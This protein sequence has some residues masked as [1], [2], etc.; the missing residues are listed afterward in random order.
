[1]ELGVS[2]WDS[3]THYNV[4]AAITNKGLCKSTSG[5]SFIP[6][7]TTTPQELLK[8]EGQ[9]GDGN[10]HFVKVFGI[11]IFVTFFYPVVAKS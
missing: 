4:A 5:L 11:W 8:E 2:V 10:N 9:G 3:S 1:M 6:Q 7:L